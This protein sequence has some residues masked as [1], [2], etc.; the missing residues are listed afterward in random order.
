M[1]VLGKRI[2]R[3]KFR[4]EKVKESVASQFLLYT[5]IFRMFKIKRMAIHAI[6]YAARMSD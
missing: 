2:L 6:K 5:N 1:K 3:K 4:Y